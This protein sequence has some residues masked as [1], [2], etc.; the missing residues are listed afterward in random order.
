MFK[1]TKCWKISSSF[2]VIQF[3]CI[4]CRMDD[5]TDNQPKTYIGFIKDSLY[6]GQP[7]KSVLQKKPNLFWDGMSD[8]YIALS[9]IEYG[10]DSL[11]A[12][13]TMGAVFDD[14]NYLQAVGIEILITTPYEVAKDNDKVRQWIERELKPKL[15]WSSLTVTREDTVSSTGSFYYRY[16]TKLDGRER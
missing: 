13:S 8:G 12:L 6:I 16:Q 14:N 4:G 7:L 1:N 3:L 9:D 5:C 15:Y 11:S 10:S 2:A